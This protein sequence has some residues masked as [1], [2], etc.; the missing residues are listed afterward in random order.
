[1]TKAQLKAASKSL[2][3][4]AAAIDLKMKSDSRLQNGSMHAAMAI[5]VALAN[6]ANSAADIEE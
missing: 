5:I 2:A 3:N 4:T 6:A 1:M